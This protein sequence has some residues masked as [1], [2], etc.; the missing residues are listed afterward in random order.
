[1][2]I[3]KVGSDRVSGHHFLGCSLLESLKLLAL[4]VPV[5]PLEMSH[6]QFGHTE[7]SHF[8]NHCLPPVGTALFVSADASAFDFPQRGSTKSS[9]ELRPAINGRFW[10]LQK[11]TAIFSAKNTGFFLK[12]EVL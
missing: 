9:A 12:L 5:R 8:V 1:M 7:H 2:K 6:A 4:T 10:V 11:P 3:P